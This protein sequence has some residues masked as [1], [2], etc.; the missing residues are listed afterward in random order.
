MGSSSVACL[1][2]STENGSVHSTLKKSRRG[3]ALVEMVQQGRRG[4][5]GRGCRNRELCKPAPPPRSKCS[6]SWKSRPAN[7]EAESE[8][9]GAPNPQ[10]PSVEGLVAARRR[11]GS[12]P[13]PGHGQHHPTTVGDG[14]PQENATCDAALARLNGQQQDGF[15]A[16][17]AARPWSA[18]R[19]GHRPVP[20]PS[21]GRACPD[22]HRNGQAPRERGHP[23]V[24]SKL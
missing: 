19:G 17:G 18:G 3:S 6:P 22:T 11:P 20:G 16:L 4:R 5:A 14:Q 24:Q 10:H 13:A 23:G 12:E 8:S 7:G 15:H 2:V 21:G 1:Y 9:D